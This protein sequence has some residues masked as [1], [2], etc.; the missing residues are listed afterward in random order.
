MNTNT[1]PYNLNI[2][3][4]IYEAKGECPDVSELWD[5]RKAQIYVSRINKAFEEGNITEEEKNFLIGATTRLNIFFY[6]KIAEY[7]CHSNSVMQDLME[8]LALVIIDYDKAIENGYVKLSK[9]IQEK[10]LSGEW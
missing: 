7:Y 6:D 2:K 4:P 5:D 9:A 3:S 8:Q 1:D 10:L